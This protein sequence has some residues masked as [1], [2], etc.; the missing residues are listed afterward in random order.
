MGSLAE[1]AAHLQ[2]GHPTPAERCANGITAATERLHASVKTSVGP[3]TPLGPRIGCM[4]AGEIA[5]ETLAT[6]RGVTRLCGEGPV[7]GRDACRAA[8]P[9]DRR[10]QGAPVA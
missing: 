3:V 7:A 4:P 1:S 9:R 6:G 8:A 2:Q 5:E 10:G